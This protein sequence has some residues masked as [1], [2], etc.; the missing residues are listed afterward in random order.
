MRF[1]GLDIAGAY[2]IDPEP[3]E[4][5]RGYFARWYD[6]EAFDAHGLERTEVQGAVSHN[7]RSGTLRGLHFIPEADGEAKLVRCVKGRVFDVIADVRSGSATFGKWVGAELSAAA[8]NS[9]Y[10]P[11]GCAHGFITLEDDCDVAYQF[12]MPFRPGLETGVLWNDPD[13][14]VE[15]PAEPVVISDRDRALLPL[16]DMKLS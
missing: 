13:I 8:Y 7:K 5:A 15:W 12:S 9:L 4:D 3:I 11:R 14:N 2:R 10:V 6:A 1:T 16:K